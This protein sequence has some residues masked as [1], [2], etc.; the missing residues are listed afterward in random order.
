M[1]LVSLPSWGLSMDEIIE[2]EGLYYKKF[3]DVP[4][5]GSVDEGLERGSFKDGQLQGPYVRYH[6]NG[7]LKSKGNFKNNKREGPWVFYFQDGNLFM[8]GEYRNGKKEDY[9]EHYYMGGE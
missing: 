3:T 9:W 7:Q 1:S 2:R 8:K 6:K 4:F 5:T